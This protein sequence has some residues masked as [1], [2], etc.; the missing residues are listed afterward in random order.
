MSNAFRHACIL[1]AWRLLDPSESASEPRIRDSVSEILDSVANI[2]SSSP[3]LELMVLP[4]FLAGADSLVAHSRH[5]V[6]LRFEQIKARSEIGNMAFLTL[7]EKVWNARAE[8]PK[9]DTSN[10]PWMKF[11]SIL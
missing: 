9:H 3:L 7:L 6:I 8:Q 1:R 11:V 10:I 2:P 4:L 5:Y